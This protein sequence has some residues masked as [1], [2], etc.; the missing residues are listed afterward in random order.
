MAHN[1]PRDRKHQTPN[2]QFHSQSKAAV[3]EAVNAVSWINQSVGSQPVA[4]EPFIKT[5]LAG[6]QRLLAKPRRKKEPIMLAMLKGL[7][8][9]AGSSPSLSEARTV[10]IALVAFSAFLKVDEVASLCCCDVQ[11][12]PGHMVIKIL[13]SKTDQLHQGDEFVVRSRSAT[14]PVTRHEQYFS[15][16]AINPDNTEQLFRGIVHT[17]NGE[18]LRELG[19][20]SYTRIRELLQ[21]KLQSLGYDPALFGTH[22]FRAGGPTLAANQVVQDQMF[23][24]HGQWRS[25]TAK[26]GYVKDSMEARLEVSKK[27]GL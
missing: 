27:L 20:L 16:A 12:Y 4:L 15:L 5:V 24:R 11:F 2:C 10:A 13:S 19:S 9:A 25:E 7:V 18:K 3:E 6:L 22:S 21:A 1:W 17:R 14:C 26:D 23:K 8:D